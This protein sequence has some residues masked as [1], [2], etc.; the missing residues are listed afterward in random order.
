M[1]IRFKRKPSSGAGFGQ[2]PSSPSSRIV[3]FI[4]GIPFFGMGAFFCWMT[5]IQPLLLS[6][7]S[8]DWPQVECRVVSSDVGKH[9]SDDGYTYSIDIT[10]SYQYEGQSYTG[11]SYNFNKTNSSGRDGKAKVVRQF[12]KGSTH[13]CWVNPEDPTVAV[14]NR[15][16]PS[17]VFIMIPFTSIFMCVGLGCMLGGLGLFPKKWNKFKSRHQPVATES[18]GSDTLKPRHSGGMKVIGVVLIACF[19][20]GITSVFVTIVVKSHLE[21]SPEWFL[22]FFIIPFVLVGILLIF[23]VF[24]ALLGLSNPS[25]TLQLSEA[26]PCLGQGLRVSWSA[27]KPLHK[28]QQ[29]TLTLV[30]METATYRRGSNSTTD[31]CCFYKEVLLDTD[32]ASQHELGELDIEIPAQL[33]HSFNGGNN[34]IKWEFQI[35]GTIQTWPDIEQTFPL[36][37]RPVSQ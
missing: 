2:D 10:F 5:A 36:T 20:N 14:L 17:I 11:G 8:K 27:S 23:G 32:Q 18:I 21:G 4:F 37:V 19:W 16:I 35:E 13:D 24:N 28:V 1:A 31:T 34:A 26:Q 30:G 25:F 7:D 3:I 6:L 29:L 9:R 22:T 15:S 12:P 33:M